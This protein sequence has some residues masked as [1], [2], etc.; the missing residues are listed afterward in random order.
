MGCKIDILL[1]PVYGFVVTAG[2]DSITSHYYR[3]SCTVKFGVVSSEQKQNIV[4]N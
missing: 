2:V 1:Y 3:V 4:L